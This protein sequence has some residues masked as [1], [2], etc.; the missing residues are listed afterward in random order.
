MGSKGPCVVWSAWCSV[1]CSRKV[2]AGG[3]QVSSGGA[4]VQVWW[5]QCA[6][7]EGG[8]KG[9]AEEMGVRCVQVG[10]EVVVGASLGRQVWGMGKSGKWCVYVCVCKLGHVAGGQGVKFFLPPSHL[11]TSLSRRQVPP[12]VQ[13][14]PPREFTCRVLPRGEI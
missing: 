9:V 6:G 4:V 13:S 10:G 3:R 12:K 14:P 11:L 1:V 7:G 8:E 2:V 5:W